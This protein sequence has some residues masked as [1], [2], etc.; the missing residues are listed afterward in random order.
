MQCQGFDKKKTK[1]KYKLKQMPNTKQV[2]YG[3]QAQ[4]PLLATDLIGW[5]EN[6]R[7]GR[8]II[9]PIYVRL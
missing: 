6:Q 9:T 7:K 1:N 3:K 2:N 4:Y 8:Y 5:V